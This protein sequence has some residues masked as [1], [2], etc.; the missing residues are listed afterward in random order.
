M[1]IKRNLT[2]AAIASVIAVPAFAE[3][4]NIGVPSWTGAQAIAYVLGE[5]SS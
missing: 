4:V 1:T 3:E 5:V 2:A